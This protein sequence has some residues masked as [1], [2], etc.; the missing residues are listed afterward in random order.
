MKSI[1]SINERIKDLRVEKGLNLNELSAETGLPA[2]TLSDYEQDYAT[3]PHTSVITLADYFG[4]S[5]DFL[6]GMTDVRLSETKEIS[7]LHL[8]DKAIEK[9][10]D[11]RI[12][13]RLLSELIENDGFTDLMM[14]AESYVDGHVEDSIQLSNRL[15]EL[16]RNRI[17][18]KYN[19]PNDVTMNTLN[20]IHYAQE[21][22]FAGVLTKDLIP[23]LADIKTAHKKDPTT[24]DGGY[25][26]E[27]ILHIIEVVTNT[28]GGK[29]KKISAMYNELFRLGHSK[30]N[31]DRTAEILSK[32][33][34]DVDDVAELISRSKLIEPNVREARRKIDSI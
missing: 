25:S 8:S 20:H 24:S 30:K 17:T 33:D 29:R 18:E 22:Y 10:K 32:E 1:V 19:N 14:D 26:A 9:L 3:V 27:D 15:M 34:F 5:A 16:A 12:N 23:I 21:D 4:V 28:K 2:S 11:E 6:L 13:S 7:D 31:I